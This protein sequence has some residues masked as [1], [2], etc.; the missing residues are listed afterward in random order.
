MIPGKN[1]SP[2]DQRDKAQGVFWLSTHGDVQEQTSPYITSFNIKEGPI[3]SNTP[4]GPGDLQKPLVPKA[5][6]GS[7]SIKGP[8]HKKTHIHS[9][10]IIFIGLPDFLHDFFLSLGTSFNTAFNCNSPFRIIECQVLQSANETGARLISK[11]QRVI[12]VYHS[13]AMTSE[14][15]GFALHRA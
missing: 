10:N 14:R 4:A 12:Q 13:S 9:S 5:F 6:H 1:F 15:V 2:W 8:R 3:L 11:Q 7:S